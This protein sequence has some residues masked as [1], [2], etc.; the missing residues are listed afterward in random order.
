VGGE[1]KEGE[2]GRCLVYT[3]MDV[4]HWKWLKLL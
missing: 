1:G 2:Y 4:E 3:C